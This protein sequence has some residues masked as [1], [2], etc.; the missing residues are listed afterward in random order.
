MFAILILAELYLKQVSADQVERHESQPMSNTWSHNQA[1]LPKSSNRKSGL[2][3][4]IWNKEL[5]TKTC[6]SIQKCISFSLAWYP[7]IC[8]EISIF[9]LWMKL[10]YSCFIWFVYNAVGRI[11]RLDLSLRESYYR[12]MEQFETEIINKDMYSSQQYWPCRKLFFSLYFF[13]WAIPE[14]MLLNNILFFFTEIH[15]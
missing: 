3:H 5:E 11:W 2:I 4:F 10:D 7:I 14:K 8:F 15:F 13:F 1:S 6:A 9:C 12:G